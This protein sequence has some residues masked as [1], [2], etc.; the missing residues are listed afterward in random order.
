MAQ[1]GCWE[2]LRLSDCWEEGCDGPRWCVVRL[3]AN[4]RRRRCCSACGRSFRAVHDRSERKVR[5]LPIFEIPVELILPRLR[6]ACRRCGPKLERLDWLS[7]YARVTARLAVSVARLRHH[8]W[9]TSLVR[10][11]AGIVCD[12]RRACD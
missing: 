5:D 4:A 12:G 10:Q 8:Y 3:E 11:A 7:S 9:G 2:G 6:L 1:F